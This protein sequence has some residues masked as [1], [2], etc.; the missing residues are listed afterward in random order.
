MSKTLVDVLNIVYRNILFH[1]A[2]MI[3]RHN[4]RS[5]FGKQRQTFC[6]GMKKSDL[7][8]IHSICVVHE[9]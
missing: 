2:K 5:Q 9:V 6:T 3:S 4:S 1:V 8:L 7:S